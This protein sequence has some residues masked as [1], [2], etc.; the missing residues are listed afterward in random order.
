MAQSSELP[1]PVDINAQGLIGKAVDR[2]DGPL[3]VCGR[4]TYAYEYQPEDQK[5]VYGF[6]LGSAIAKGSIEAFDLRRAQSAPGVLLIMTHE[7][8]PSQEPFGPPTHKEPLERPK[9]FLVDAKIRYYGEPVAFVVAETFEQ[10][11]DAAGLIAV[12]Y[13]MESPKGSV[14]R[15]KNEAYKPKK[16]NAG[17]ETDSSL[18]DFDKAF[19]EA[20]VKVDA[21]YTTPYQHQQPMEPHATMAVWSGDKVT[22][23]CGHQLPVS[24]HKSVAKTLKLS[25]K[26]VRIICK[27]V[28]GGF[29]S[30]L[31]T[32]ADMIL[33]ALA[34]RQLKMPVKTAITRQQ[35]FFNVPHRPESIQRIRLGAG[36]DGKLTA[37]AHESW[38]QTATYDEFGEAAGSATRS[39]YAAPNRMTSHRLV[40]LDLPPSGSMRAPG[41]AIGLLALEQ[42]MDELA[43][44]LNID[45]VKLRLLNEPKEDPEKKIP[46]STRA[47]PACLMEGAKRFDWDKRSPTPGRMRDGKWL[48]GYGMSA[49]YRPNF[50][51]PSKARVTLGKDGKLTVKM[52]MTDIGTGSYTIFTQLAAEILQMP[53]ADVIIDIGDSDLP[54]TPGSGGSF[55]ANSAGSGLFDACMNLR[56][57]LVKQAVA[58]RA[59]PLY[60]LK[61]KDAGWKEGNIVIGGKKDSPRAVAA[62]SGEGITAEGSIDALKT[63]KT[64]SQAAYGA[65]FVEVGVD[66]DTGE[67][68]LRRMLGV[69]A[70]GRILNPKTARSQ[71]IGGMIWGV[72]AAL[73]EASIVDQRYGQFVNHDYAEYHVPV[74]ADIKNIEAV[75]LP[76][77]DDKTGPLKIKGVGELGICGSGAA[78]MNAVYNACGVRVR[79]YPVTVDKIIAKLA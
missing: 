66:S 12:K 8:A 57:A 46:F 63:Y 32:E 1:N 68:R 49:A 76:E 69:F 43:E 42:A 6:I 13:S 34:A 60:G 24:A 30:K 65:H 7:N 62:R 73:H 40:K 33:T 16:M 31:P 64:Y 35:E 75:Y 77:V 18:G 56:E 10:A 51:R 4:A 45:P 47:L 17:V 52:A 71:A 36:A 5:A 70:A 19:A 58:D 39:L 78:V 50:L 72:S 2:V 55:G 41:E 74:H 67:I 21:T 44:K 14:E 54:P 27:Y 9:P 37:I 59:S 11:R 25:E 23:Y 15:F 61:A 26:N 79:D 20:P 53:I 28:G 48:V 38:L 22:L 29:G 3:K